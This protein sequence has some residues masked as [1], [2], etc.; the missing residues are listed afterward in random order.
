V[1]APPS[2]DEPPSST[3]PQP[4]RPVAARRARSTPSGRGP[5]APHADA[6]SSDRP[7]HSSL[8]GGQ[9]SPPAAAGAPSGVTVRGGGRTIPTVPSDQILQGH[10][11]VNIEHNGR[12]YQ[13]R[14]TRQGKLILTK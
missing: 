3:T 6:V 12:V 4:V 13:L 8:R 11:A 5:G 10:D 1:S 14:R 2:G 9:A 7:A